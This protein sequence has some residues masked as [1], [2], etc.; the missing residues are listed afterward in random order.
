ML[1]L[2]PFLCGTGLAS[3]LAGLWWYSSMSKDQQVEADRRANALAYKLYQTSI[4]NLTE[5]QLGVVHRMVK[6][7]LV[8]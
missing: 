7:Q 4:E 1:P 6:Q 5:S 8:G 3:S 2:I